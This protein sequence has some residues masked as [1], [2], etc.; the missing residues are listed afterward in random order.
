[1]MTS[2]II[3]NMPGV[4][5]DGG[6]IIYPRSRRGTRK[7]LAPGNYFFMGGSMEISENEIQTLR[8]EWAERREERDN[9]AMIRLQNL[10]MWCAGVI[11]DGVK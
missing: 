2:T 7:G 10:A 8:N 4:R 11:S 5:N 3:G 1:M 9:Q 6:I